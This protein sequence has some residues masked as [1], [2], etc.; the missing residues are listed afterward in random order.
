M[1]TYT[2]NIRIRFG[3]RVNV[4]D[5]LKERISRLR[6]S[7]LFLNI[8]KQCSL[9][10]TS[11]SQI[12]LENNIIN[13]SYKTM[14]KKKLLNRILQNTACPTG[15]WGRIILR[16][17]NRFHAPLSEW[18]MGMVEWEPAWTVLDIGCG[19]GANVTRLLKLCHKGTVHGIDISKESVAFASK[20]NRRWINTRCFIKQG[21]VCCLP[22]DDG[23]FEAVTSFETVYFWQDVPA[24]LNEVKRVL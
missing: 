19:G 6:F 5:E 23:Q 18:A 12:I 7:P 11:G 17:M 10:E 4:S 8:L 16:G 2:T 22:Y 9:L 3:L 24:A 21:N 20:H 13:Q 14:K 1:E 15:F